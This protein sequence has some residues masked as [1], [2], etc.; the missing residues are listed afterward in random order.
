MS[1]IET[2]LQ[3]SRT[4][5]PPPASA[6]GFPFSHIP[7]LEDYRA[8][9]KLSITNPEQFWGNEAERLSWFKPYQR[10]LDWQP[11]DAKWF[12][13]G[14]LNACYNCVD[15]HVQAGHGDEIALIWEGEPVGPR[16]SHPA[17]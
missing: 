14:L 13:G 8:L 10:V 7:S 9:H 15:R 17:P 3:E 6:L 11:P 16:T 12:T 1:S 4:F 2:V 5:P